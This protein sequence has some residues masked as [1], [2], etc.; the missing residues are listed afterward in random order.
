MIAWCKNNDGG[1]LHDFQKHW[2]AIEKTAEAEVCM[3]PID[4][5]GILTYSV[6]IQE[7]LCRCDGCKEAGKRHVYPLCT[8]SDQPVWTGCCL[9]GA[10]HGGG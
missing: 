10:V 3:L 1:L 9:G 2:D 5:R 4:T 6:G 7:G 8:V